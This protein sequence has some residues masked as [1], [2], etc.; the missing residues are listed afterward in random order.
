L[1]ALWDPQGKRQSSTYGAGWAP[2]PSRP[3]RGHRLVG[4]AATL[5]A[6]RLGLEAGDITVVLGDTDLVPDGT[7]SWASRSTVLTGNAVALAAD[8]V[9]ELAREAAAEAL[10]VDPADLRMSDGRFEAAGSP[11]RAVSLAELAG[12]SGGFSARETFEI[13]RMTYP[14]GVHLAHVEVDPDSGGVRILGYFIGYEVGR[15]VIKTLVEGQLVGG[16]AQGIADALR[17]SKRTLE[18]SLTRI[19]SLDAHASPT[20]ASAAVSGLL[21][22]FALRANNRTPAGA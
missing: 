10:E 18:M 7:G 9:A 22:M 20:S 12:R 17:A 5:A 8:R 13:D 1:R 19:Q 2:A 4:Q 3:V 16:A 11:E 6:E 14:Y 15:A 21:S